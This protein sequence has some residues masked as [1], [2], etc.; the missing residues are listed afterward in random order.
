MSRNQN[1]VCKEDEP[2]K[3]IHFELVIF[4]MQTDIMDPRE[5]FLLYLE[6]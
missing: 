6:K 2:E 1:G 5:P 4:W 3:K